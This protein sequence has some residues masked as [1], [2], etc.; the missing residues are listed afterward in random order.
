MK[1]RNAEAVRLLGKTK[2]LSWA[3]TILGDFG[4]IEISLHFLYKKIEENPPGKSR[5]KKREN[6]PKEENQILSKILVLN[7][8]TNIGAFRSQNPSKRSVKKVQKRSEKDYF[9]LGFCS[10]KPQC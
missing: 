2:P 3:L 7:L 5:R 4:E 9:L 10:G 8:V 1:T 6:I